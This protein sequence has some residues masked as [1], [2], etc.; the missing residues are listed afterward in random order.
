MGLQS[1]FAG[2]AR[3]FQMIYSYIGNGALEG[4]QR[5][6]RGDADLEIDLLSFP[7]NFV[8]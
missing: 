3:P 6:L 8:N 2:R 7:T 4:R 5:L 1:R